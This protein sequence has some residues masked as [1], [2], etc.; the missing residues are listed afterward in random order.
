LN[1]VLLRLLLQLLLLMLLL[2][3][4]LSLI[5]LLLL[6]ELAAGSAHQE[7]CQ[8]NTSDGIELHYSMAWRVRHAKGQ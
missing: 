1:P 2:L 7:P 6:S 5:L 3:L 4:L 8:S